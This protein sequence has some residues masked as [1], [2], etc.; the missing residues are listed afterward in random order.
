MFP[1][2]DRKEKALKD[3]M[4]RLNIREEDLEESFI[5]S[6]GAGGQNVNKTSSC[7]LLHHLPSGIR[8]KC[9]K[10]RSQ[11]LNRYLARKILLDKIEIELKG[12][13][14]S[15]KKRIEKIRRQKR[16]RSRRAQEKIL[17]TKHRISAQKSMRAKVTRANQDEE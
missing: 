12:R 11:A 13:E 10:E 17:E 3:K 9:Q 2:S 8:V 15:E 5:R 16:K 1:V 7:V 14:S 6:S 4:E